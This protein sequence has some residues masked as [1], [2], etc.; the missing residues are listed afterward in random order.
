M[1]KRL[2]TIFYVFSLCYTFTAQTNADCPWEL[3]VPQNNYTFC[4]TDCEDGNWVRR[5]S[6][7]NNILMDI[8]VVG[9]CTAFAV[10]YNN[11]I[12]R[13]TNNG[14]T[15]VSL[16]NSGMNANTLFMDVKFINNT[17]G[18]VV[19]SN[20]SVLRTTNGGNSW[21][22]IAP[23]TGNTN[24]RWLNMW[25]FDESTIIIVGDNN[26]A[27][28]PLLAR[29]TDGGATWTFIE[30][31]A[32]ST[33]Y[34]M[35]FIDNNTGFISTNYGNILRTTDGGNTWTT[36]L[37]Q[38]QD[39]SSPQLLS[40]YFTTPNNGFAV[41]G[42]QNNIGRVYQTTDGGLTWTVV[43]FNSAQNDYYRHIEF[44]NALT[45]YITGGNIT[46][47]SSIIFRTTDGGATWVL[48]STNFS[49]LNKQSISNVNSQYAV[50]L[51]GTIIKLCQGNQVRIQ[52]KGAQS[53]I[54]SNG[55]TSDI[56]AVSPTQATTYTVSGTLGGCTQSEVITINVPALAVNSVTTCSGETVVLSAQ[57]GT[58]FIWSNGST[59]QSI[60]VT[61]SST[62]SYTVSALFGCCRQ[63]AVANIFIANIPPNVTVDS[64]TICSGTNVDLIA[65]GATNYTWSPSMGLNTTTGSTV[66]ANP[67]ETT[68]YTVT[69]SN[70]CGTDIKTVT[71]TVKNP[72]I[73][74]LQTTNTSICNGSSITLVAT[75]DAN[76]YSWSPSTGLNT[77]YGATVVANPTETTTYTVIGSNDCG[78]DVKTVTITVK[79]NPTVFVNNPQICEGLDARLIAG[80][81]DSYTWSEGISPT[82]I[83]T[84]T[85]APTITT[86]YTVTGYKDGCEGTVVSTVTV[87]PAPVITVN[88]ETICTGESATLNA[89]GAYT[90]QWSTGET[91]NSIT[92]SPT[93]TTTYT[94]TGWSR[95]CA[96]EGNVAVTTV[97]VKARPIVTASSVTTCYGET[98]F[99]EADGADTYTWSE[100][101]TPIGI[102]TAIS[103]PSA[104]TTYTVVGD[105]NGCKDEAEGTITVPFITVNS[106]IICQ[107][108]SAVLTAQ[109][110]NNYVWSNGA[111]TESIVVSPNATQSYTV[112]AVVKNC[113]RC[114]ASAEATVTVKPNPVV[115]ISGPT[116]VCGANNPVTMTAYGADSYYWVK[117]GGGN[118]N[119]YTDYPSYDYDYQVQGTTNGCS[120]LS[121]TIR[122]SVKPK[123]R[124]TISAVNTGIF[125]RRLTA[126][127]Q[128]GSG[129]G[130]RYQWYRS[131]S[132]NGPWTIINGAT[133]NTYTFNRNTNRDYFGVVVTN[134]D[135]CDNKINNQI[136][137]SATGRSYEEVT[138]YFMLSPESIFDATVPDND[139]EIVLSPN[140]NNGNMSLT[141]YLGEADQASMSIYDISGR[142]VASYSLNIQSGLLNINNEQLTSGV[143]FYKVIVDNQEVKRDKIIIVK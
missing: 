106:A 46:N 11:T 102:N 15:W 121:N 20:N 58:N 120:S 137:S 88:S 79:P 65:S 16:N 31:G 4:Q 41:G 28:S 118:A 14:E 72:P 109:G 70:A 127:I 119:P 48:M 108:Q 83:N 95:C 24:R 74:T 2:L 35:F 143:Y 60:T 23:T 93:S 107:G 21:T 9:E 134:S 25:V 32:L 67:I 13:S 104:T 3:Q 123:P 128:S 126:N 66:I 105:V 39:N 40:I 52:A 96:C 19:G 110:G 57:G 139:I 111:T 77:I 7:T 38:V 43:N 55:S 42:R 116:S 86:T 33:I 133:S 69:G 99:L 44:E 50:G 85:A 64:K 17:T 114:N 82:G 75:G 51:D 100:G 5:N 81:A 27:T 12:L 125:N 97:T 36:Q 131:S 73:I 129:T 141:Y 49:R 112:T 101:I 47:N 115:T 132:S 92:V 53:Y 94:V 78:A 45:G 1:K 103:N 136:P 29:T 138:E 140:P 34:G 62:T 124:V 87:K 135:G 91:S 59:T 10:G 56:I 90:Y 130:F 63:S 22:N 6:N 18:F 26:S 122:V 89:T 117:G 142:I 80:G 98:A 61:E 71:V 8:D 76:V 113:I 30:T 68:T 84:A 54:W 37:N